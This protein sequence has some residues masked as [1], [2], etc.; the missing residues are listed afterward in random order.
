MILSLVA[1]LPRCAFALVQLRFS[2]LSRLQVGD[3]NLKEICG[4][5]HLSVGGC[6][7][8]P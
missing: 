7:S 1:A 8:V 3:P 6:F 5:A 4:W 2:G